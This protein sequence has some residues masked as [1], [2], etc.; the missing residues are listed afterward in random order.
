MMY[1][2]FSYAFFLLGR[3]LIQLDML[4]CINI[5]VFFMQI[6]FDNLIEG[7]SGGK[8]FSKIKI[9]HGAI[10]CK[11]NNIYEHIVMALSVVN[12][13]NVIYIYIYIQC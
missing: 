13:R 6:V 3:N 9:K 10:K 5:V 1:N 12:C 4:M 11:E 7:R 2:L 8:K